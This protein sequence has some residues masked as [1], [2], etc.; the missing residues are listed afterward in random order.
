MLLRCWS[1]I[2]LVKSSAQHKLVAGVE[3]NVVALT[4]FFLH[5]F[6]NFPYILLVRGF[7]W[8][9]NLVTNNLRMSHIEVSIENFILTSIGVG[10]IVSFVFISSCFHW[11]EYSVFYRWWNHKNKFTIYQFQID[12]IFLITIRSF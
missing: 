1:S 8:R 6:F 4:C 3:D 5:V 2:L 10:S 9:M 7:V 11:K 12:S